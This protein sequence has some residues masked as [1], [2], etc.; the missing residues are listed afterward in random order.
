MIRFIW[1]NRLMHDEVPM[2]CCRYTSGE[3]RYWDVLAAGEECTLQP[4]SSALI[5][6]ETSEEGTISNYPTHVTINTSLTAAGY[7]QGLYYFAV[8]VQSQTYCCYASWLRH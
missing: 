2:G 4:S 3:V 5:L 1:D 6:D 8:H 7:S